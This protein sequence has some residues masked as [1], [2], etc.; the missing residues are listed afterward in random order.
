MPP[1]FKKKALKDPFSALPETF[2]DGCASAQ[3][4]ELQERLA[5]T[6]KSEEQNQSAMKADVDLKAKVEQA[7]VARQPYKETTKLNRL[8]TQYIIRIL[9]DRGDTLCQDILKLGAAKA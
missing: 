3:T 2:K 4:G 7:N 8:K 9:A 6:A 1:K 5:Q